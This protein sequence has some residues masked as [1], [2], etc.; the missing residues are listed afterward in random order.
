VPVTGEGI[1]PTAIS[2]RAMAE[3]IEAFGAGT[4]RGLRITIV[5]DEDDGGSTWDDVAVERLG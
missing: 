2:Y 4:G 3:Q 5:D 1:E